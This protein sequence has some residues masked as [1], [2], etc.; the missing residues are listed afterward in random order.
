MAFIALL[1]VVLVIY[2]VIKRHQRQ[3]GLDSWFEAFFSY[4]DGIV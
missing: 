2:G 3:E 4:I 1:L